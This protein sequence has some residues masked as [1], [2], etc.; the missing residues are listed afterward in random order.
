M[1]PAASDFDSSGTTRRASNSSRVPSPAQ[2]GQ[3]PCGLLNE[4]MRGAISGIGD[5]AVGAGVALRE[6]VLAR[7]GPD[8]DQHQAVGQAQRR[9]DRL[10]DP[11]AHVRASP[12]GGRP[13]RRSSASP[14]WRAR[15]PRRARAARRRSAPARSP[16]CG[17]SRAPCG[18][19]PSGRA[20]RAPGSARA[21]RSPS[22]S[23]STKSVICCTVW[24][25]I[26]LPQRVQCG[27]PTRAK[28][29]RR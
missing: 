3:A 20:R 26:G 18:T 11:G 24:L 15:S 14:S 25:A 7:S 13:P 22:P 6:Q 29:R 17:S 2:A 9:L 1:A 4:N 19:R 27:C 10:G 8:V 16:A 28:S 5:A 12:P 23:A 21:G